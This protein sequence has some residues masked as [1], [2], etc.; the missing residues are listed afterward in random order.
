MLL[1][2][3]LIVGSASAWG[4]SDY[5]AVETSNCTLTAGTN[6]SSCTVNGKDGIKVGTS[7]KGGTMTVTVPSGAKYLHVHAA[8]WNGVNELSLNI[9]PDTNISPKSIALTANAGIANSSPF[10]LSGEGVSASDFYFVIAFTN[11]LTSETVFTFTTSTAKRF[12]IWGVNSEKPAIA[13]TNIAFSEPKTASVSVGGTTTLTP[14]ILPANYTETVDWESDNTDVATVSSTGVVTGVASGT[15]HITAKSHGNPSTIYDVC[16]VTV[17]AP[18]SVTGV[19]LK[20]STTLILGETETLEATVLP[21]EATNKNVTWTSA[22]DTKVSVD[23]NGV[24]TGLALTGE[25]PVNITVTTVD[26][27]FSAT[28][29]VTVNPIPVTSVSLNKT[30]AALRVGKTLTLSATVKPDEANQNVTWSSSEETVATVDANGKVTAIAEGT[31]TITAQ[32]VTDNTKEAT[33]TV[34]VTDG[35]I[36]LRTTGEITF[37]NP[38][39]SDEIGSGGY[40]TQDCELNGSDGNKY[41]W[42]EVDG[43]LNGGWQ[44]KKTSGKVTSPVIKSDYGFTISVTTGTNDVTI[45]DGTNSGKNSLTT[46]KNSATITIVGDGAY[47]VFTSIKITPS[48]L[49]VATEVAITDPGT[50]AT[51]DTGTFAFTATTEEDNTASWASATA[52]VI[53][54]TDAAT[55]AYTAAGRGT[56]KITLTLTPTDASTYE[57]VTAERT[58]T[59]M[60]P[61]VITASNVEMTYGDAAKSI[62][63]TTTTGYTGT[64]SY[65]SDNEAIA[66]V[67]STGVVTAVSVGTT[68]ITISAPADAANYY[69]AGLDK[70][71]N[72]TVSA[73]T[74]VATAKPTSP[75]SVVSNTLLSS[76]LPTSWIGDGSIWSG[77]LNYGAVTAAGT[78]GNSYDLMTETINLEGNYTAASVTFEHTGNKT[79]STSGTGRAE[80][81]KLYVKDGSTETQLSINT[82]F[83]GNNWTYV[84]NTTDLTDYLGKSIQLIFRYTPSS[85]NQGKWEVKNFAV[86]ATPAPTESVKLNGSGYATFCS[87]YPLDFTNASGFSAWQITS[88]E[89]DVITF[90]QIIGSVKGGTGILLKGTAGETVTINSSS[91]TNELSS[92]K[93]VGTLA[94]TYVEDDTYYGLSGEYFKKVSAGKVPAGKALLPASEVP[95]NAR[96]TFVFE[97]AQGIKAIEHSP[98]TIDDSVYNLSGQRVTTPKK[99]LYIVNGKKVMVK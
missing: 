43:Y 97:D 47:A 72:V 77:D 70:V 22:D 7:S 65:A 74:G 57:A 8:A 20:S 62:G 2:C 36:D 88:I 58:V 34:T 98:L 10:T 59:V 40:K 1:L 87:Q 93:L 18:V 15:A 50:L 52:G 25:T 83:A 30:T 14:T 11:V 19:S 29:A 63:A 3:A 78:I 33:C 96:L 9:T 35:A 61:V 75:V 28:C 90:S 42:A 26:G 41:T 69:T 51:G 94:P 24:I 31:A 68:T 73:P 44:I 92:N 76:S 67:S 39:T 12:V 4:Q 55:G 79:F 54:I 85:G 66:T 82:M 91:S 86:N 71:I 21:N 99:G 5:S 23:E 64:L 45:S 16:T 46:T 32:S 56:S 48:K 80:A 84:T 38:F 95:S 49:P 53:T 89:N 27:N 60:E 13:I 6:G 37:G 17:T 81:C